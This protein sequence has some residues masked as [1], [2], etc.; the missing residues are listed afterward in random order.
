MSELNK[1][2]DNLLLK[3]AYD[4]ERVT[5]QR[6]TNGYVTRNPVASNG[7]TSSIPFLTTVA[8]SILIDRLESSRCRIEIEPARTPDA[9]TVVTVYKRRCDDNTSEHIV[10]IP[11]GYEVPGWVWN[12]LYKKPFRVVNTPFNQDASEA[13]EDKLHLFTERGKGFP[14]PKLIMYPEL[15]LGDVETGWTIGSPAFCQPQYRRPEA[16]DLAAYAKA[17]VK[18]DAPDVATVAAAELTPSL[19]DI[20]TRISAIAGLLALATANYDSVDEDDLKAATAAGYANPTV[21]S[22]V[23]DMLKDVTEDAESR[24]RSAGWD[25]GWKAKEAT[26]GD[27][28]L[29][30]ASRIAK[31]GRLRSTPEEM[32][33]ILRLVRAQTIVAELDA[34]K[35]LEDDMLDF[36]DVEAVVQAAKAFREAVSKTIR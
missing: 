34:A 21:L 13:A 11:K 2:P 8:T 7:K 25:D 26:I 6:A 29:D 9:Q 4:A 12:T 33:P 31:G 23:V 35:A 27:D 19:P 10:Y 36:D 18:P 28:G 22:A 24:G 1:K 30:T 3:V 20:D 5:L 15:G 16:A 17:V 32:D 14:K